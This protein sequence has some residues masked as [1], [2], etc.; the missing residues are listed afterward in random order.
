MYYSSKSGNTRALL[1][2]AGISALALSCELRLSTPIILVTPTYGDSLGRNCVPPPVKRFLQQPGIASL[3]Q[4][5]VACGDRNF[6]EHYAAAGDRIAAKFQ[7]PVLMKI[8]LRGTPS[9]REYLCLMHQL[10][11]N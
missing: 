4:G 11:T 10:T 5:V 3:L 8:E 6:G 9:E 1:E 2:L 7:V